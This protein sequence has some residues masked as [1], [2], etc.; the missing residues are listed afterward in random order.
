M[1]CIKWLAVGKRNILR[2]KTR[3]CK[4]EKKALVIIMC[5][6]MQQVGKSAEQSMIRPIK[7]KLDSL[8]TGDQILRNSLS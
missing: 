6:L 8:E 1:I 7:V 4:N 5:L 2:L 3:T